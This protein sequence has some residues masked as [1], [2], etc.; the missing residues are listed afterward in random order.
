MGEQFDHRR[1][2]DLFMEESVSQKLSE[3]KFELSYIKLQ[4]KQILE[5][6]NMSW[7]VPNSPT[8]E[9]KMV[10]QSSGR[11]DYVKYDEQAIKQQAIFKDRFEELERFASELKDGRAKSLFLTHLEEAY[12]WT[13]KAIRDEQIARSGGAELQEGR[14]NE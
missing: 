10:K 12:M 13:G 5:K 11:F 8:E 2:I 9:K 14:N 3:I 6:L 4:N 7:S 1:H